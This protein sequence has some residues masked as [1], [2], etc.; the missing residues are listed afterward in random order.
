MSENLSSLLCEQIVRGTRL[1]ARIFMFSFSWIKPALGRGGSVIYTRDR[2]CRGQLPHCS[3]G[4][5]GSHCQHSQ[6]RDQCAA[7]KSGEDNDQKL[8]SSALLSYAMLEVHS[9]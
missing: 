8:S 3:N 4:S 6:H 9:S 2:G 1:F 7:S 5:K